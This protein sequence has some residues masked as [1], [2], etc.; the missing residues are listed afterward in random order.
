MFEQE[1]KRA[2]DR[3]H[4]RKDL[5]KEMEKKWAAEQAQPVEEERGKI[6]AFPLWARYLGVAAGIL[7][8]VGVGM[9]SVLL[10][11]RSKGVQP[12]AADAAAPQM[13]VAEGAV[14]ME[15][16]KIVTQTTMDM[17]APEAAEEPKAMLSA[18]AAPVQG[19]HPA[20]DE[21]EV[22]D[23]VRCGGEDRGETEAEINAEAAA[24]QMK[25]AGNRQAEEANETRYPVG[26]SIRR[27]DLTAVFLPTM[28][29]IHVVKYAN[30]KVSNV[31]SLNLR[32]KGAQLQKA[33]WV[34][35]EMMAVREK[36]GETQLMRFDVGDWSAPRHL[37]NLTQSG[38]FLG[39][40]EMG[41]RIYT[42]SLYKATE[43]EPLPWVD[44]ARMDF[45]RVLLDS[46]RPGDVFTVITVYDPQAGDGFAA[47]TALLTG[48]R[49]AL[50]DLDRLLLWAGEGETE[51]YVLSA[52]DLTLETQ[53]TRS[54]TV[55]DAGLVGENY[56]L[57]L[58]QGADVAL[59]TL[60][61]EL[62][63][64]GS[65]TAA[66]AGDARFAAVYEGG[67]LVLTAEALH[68]V[69]DDGDAAIEIAGDGFTWLA[70]DRGLVMTADGKLQVVDIVG[71]EP[72][73]RGSVQIKDGLGL[74]IEDPSRLAFDLEAGR[75]V[76]PAGQKVYQY[77][78]SEAGELTQRG[79]P[80]SF[81][82]HS[83]TEQRELRVQLEGDRI[84]VFY[85]AGVV[86]YNL[87]LERQITNKY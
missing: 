62:N 51:L 67:A 52:E 43:E 2:N 25:A 22:E 32:E 23:A 38:D 57:L 87:N 44:G 56:D 31:F 59:L 20:A 69:S 77:L 17:A 80:A 9:G 21:A 3:I 75:L 29:Q 33:F 76:F 66:A 73:A 46:Q 82:D 85:K 78:V 65:V 10:Y 64:Q 14:E 81:G 74:L 16:A 4:P 55:L 45:D 41:G 15:E 12:M 83:E 68:W 47:R 34:G 50:V 36:N 48:A 24:P 49:G 27:D 54:G 61:R 86:V 8:C 58:Q 63:E 11:S 70:P 7:L 53:G 28:E 37:R 1:Y 60:D 71:H 35:S 13:M 42:L 19:M 30:R 79:T 39:A 72:V 40:W 26:E 18:A 6:V 5:L 84:L